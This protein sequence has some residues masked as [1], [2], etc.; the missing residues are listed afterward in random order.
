MNDETTF[1]TELTRRAE[2][3]HG[4]PLT[5]EDVRSRAI[6]IRRRRR[7]AAA[8]A[9]AAVVAA[10]IVLPMALTGGTHR[11]APDPAPPV[12]GHVAVLHDG[13]V[14]LPDTRTVDVGVDNADVSQLGVLTDGRIVLAMLKP[15]AVRVYEPDGTLEHQY[16][17]QSNTITMSPRDDA[18]AWVAKDYT[19]RVLETGAPEPRQLPGI[20]MGGEAVGSID[21]VL[22]A[23]HLLVGDFTTTTDRLTADGAQPLSTS[24]PFRV[25]DV[26]PDGALWAVQYAADSDPQYGC[27][28]LYDPDRERMVARSCKTSGLRFSPD[29]QHLIGMRGDNNMYGEVDVFDLGLQRVGRYSPDPRVVSRAAWSDSE[30]LLATVADIDTDPWSLV[31]VGLDG[32]DPEVVEGPVRGRN[33]EILV[34]YLL[35]D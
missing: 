5:F 26:S 9:V 24:E 12:P 23:G 1:A 18:V 33:P 14:T 16:P 30:H 34:E 3:V 11:S 32:T 8:A 29:S 7:A 22:D 15:Y 27:S 28:G 31:R 17:V 2:D 10:A 6:G 35:S 4:V 19:V 13:R 21:A 20:P 25:T